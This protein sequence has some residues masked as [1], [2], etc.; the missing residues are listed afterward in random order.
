MTY[1]NNENPLLSCNYY[2]QAYDVSYATNTDFYYGSDKYTKTN[3]FAY[4]INS[5]A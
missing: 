5:P 1:K 2:S 3:S 4:T